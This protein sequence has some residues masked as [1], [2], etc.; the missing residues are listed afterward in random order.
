L[1]DGVLISD[2]MVYPVYKL[3][4]DD[5]VCRSRWHPAVTHCL[6]QVMTMRCH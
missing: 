1:Q 2:Q 3:I 5:D 4:V 6:L